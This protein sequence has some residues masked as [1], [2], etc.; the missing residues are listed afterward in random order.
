MNRVKSPAINAAYSRSLITHRFPQSQRKLSA[1][2]QPKT[3]KEDLIEEFTS[4]G[5]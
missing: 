4:Q 1:G 5:D 3:F 2:E